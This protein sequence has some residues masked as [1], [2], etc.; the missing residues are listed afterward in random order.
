MWHGCMHRKKQLTA[1][2][3]IPEGLMFHLG[4]ED[5]KKK[6]GEGV[7]RGEIVLSEQRL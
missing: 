4:L 7:V 6:T 1:Q 2:E 5:A 3:R